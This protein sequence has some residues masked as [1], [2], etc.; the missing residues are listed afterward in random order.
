MADLPADLLRRARA[1]R[2]LVLDVDGV[3]TDGRLITLPGGPPGDIKAFHTRDGL[4]LRLAGHAGWRLALLSGRSSA[5]VEAR[6][7][8][9]GIP[10]VMQGAFPKMPVFNAWLRRHGL[11]PGEVAYMGDDI[12]DVP[13]LRHAGFAAAPAD[14]HPEAL[15]ACHW[16]S[17]LAGGAGAVREM[18]DLLLRAQ[19]AWDRVVTPLLS[20]DGVGET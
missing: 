1:V 14:A 12:V 9:L 16:V 2:A 13:V 10:D 15:A 20:E 5:A 6:A 11:P 18:V 4:G 19:G 3:L 8:E 17:R 7:A